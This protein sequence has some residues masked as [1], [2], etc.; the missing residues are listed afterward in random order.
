MDKKLKERLIKTRKAVKRKLQA[1]KEGVIARESELHKT[2]EPITKKIKELYDVGG[3]KEEKVKT[4][5]EDFDVTERAPSQV[6]S[7]SIPRFI[8]T[9]TVSEIIESEEEEGQHEEDNGTA[10]A[11]LSNI[12]S[13]AMSQGAWDEYLQ[14][15]DPLPRYYIEGLITDTT[16]T[17]DSTTGVKHDPLLNKFTLGTFEIDFVGKDILINNIKYN[18][19]PGLYE[20][21][22]KKEPSG[23]KQADEKEY[24]DI[25]NR[26]NIHRR[27]FNPNEQL[28]G[29]RSQKY[30]KIIKPLSTR[31]GP[32][33]AIAAKQ[34]RPLTP[35][36]I[37]SSAAAAA[38]KQIKPKTPT[39][40]AVVKKN[41][42]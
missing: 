15:Y 5:P 27:N 23:Y 20:L 26:T 19:T 40:L 11:N 9:D 22:F 32:A 37:A 4:E 6:L 8:E 3:I 29:N 31:T 36:A 18:G 14:Q 13:Q 30:T 10:D 16:D 35:T 7:E 24:R 21:I 39:G 25:L 12:I 2:Y 42:S 28:R 38:A 34:T 1:I 41:Y 17:Y 33:A